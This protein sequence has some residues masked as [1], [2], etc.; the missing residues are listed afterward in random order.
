[1]GLYR[2]GADVSDFGS[3]WIGDFFAMDALRP[4]TPGEIAALGGGNAFVSCDVANP[5]HV[6]ALADIWNAACGPALAISPR[7]V[8]YN[9]RPTTGGTQA[10][11]LA[12]HNG[13]PVGF[14]LASA[15]PADPLVS[16]PE[17]GWVDAI[18]VLPAHQRQ[19]FGSALLAWAEDWLWGQGCSACWLGGS[20]RPFVPGL[21]VELGTESFFL[22]KGYE[23]VSSVW[24]LSR[25]LAGY[26]SAVRRPPSAVCRLQPAHPGD[27]ATLLAFWQREFPGRWRFEYQEFLRE[28]GRLSDYMI[29][30]SERGLDGACQL[31]FEDSSRPLDRF[32]PY[33]LPRPWGQLG[34]VGISQ[35]RRGQGYG[36]AL[37]DAG[38]RRLRE[39]GVRGC[40]ID[41]TNLVDWYS[42]FGFTPYREYAI[43]LKPLTND[44]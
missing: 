9:T 7:F 14:A 19:G 4:F 12:L 1:M 8:Q 37:V 28:G 35:D 18:A 42:Q 25:D 30:C 11:Q 3:T 15:F 6:A 2:H 36:A 5:D 33:G 38:L 10:G 21:P 22:R 34:T 41:W 26:T 44:D 39:S 32:F 40:V 31:T 16:P 24:D 43:L 29:L 23:I 20:L 13:R 27:E 17:M